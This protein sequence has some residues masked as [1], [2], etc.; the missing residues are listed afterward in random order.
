M[1]G[2]L[3][4]IVAFV[5]EF[6][7]PPFPAFALSFSLAGMGNVFQVNIKYTRKEL[8]LTIIFLIRSS[9]HLRMAS[10]QLFKRTL[11]TNRVI[12][13]LYMVHLSLQ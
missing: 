8:Q 3:V 6:L 13:R 7:A 4:Q 2:A 10:S 5:L 9:L 1:V 11:I 12:Y